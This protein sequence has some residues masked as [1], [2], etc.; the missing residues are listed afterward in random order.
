MPVAVKLGRRPAVEDRRVPFLRD[1]S[2]ARALPPPPASVNWYAG[3]GSWGMLGNDT[4]G[5]CVEAMAGHATLQFTTYADRPRIPTATEAIQLYS[6]ITGYVPGDDA[7]DQGTAV[8]GP[9]GLMEHWASK[10]VVFGGARSY[11]RGCVQLHLDGSGYL[12][13][14]AHY[15]GGI[16]LGINLP[17]DI[18][19]GDSIPYLWSDPSGPIA[20]GHEVWVDGYLTENR[21]LYWDFVTWGRR[22]RMTDTFLHAVAQEAVAVYDPDSLNARGLNGDDFDAAEL[23]AAMAELRAGIA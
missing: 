6:D 11:A 15:F 20:G 13:Q 18:V 1:L 10:G 9:G 22:C 3:I 17:A 7:S 16:A 21:M 23:L 4:A 8:M 14:A 19:S 12:Q 2:A 5:D